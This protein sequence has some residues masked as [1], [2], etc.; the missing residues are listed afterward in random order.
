MGTKRL[1]VGKKQEEEK[2]VQSPCL[3]W[4]TRGKST[5]GKK[6]RR[7][8]GKEMRGE[9]QST[10][11]GGYA[12]RRDGAPAAAAG[13]A[14]QRQPPRTRHGPTLTTTE[15]HLRRR[16]QRVV[17]PGR[18][19]RRGPARRAARPSASAAGTLAVG[20][21]CRPARGGSRQ[22]RPRPRRR[23]RARGRRRR[24]PAAPRLPSSRAA[25][26]RAPGGAAPSCAG[27]GARGGRV[28][29]EAG[30]ASPCGRGERRVR[31]RRSYSNGKTGISGISLTLQQQ[32]V[33]WTA[34]GV[35]TNRL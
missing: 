31:G 28:S 11:L 30:A 6:G 32:W 15:S 5:R 19:S 18:Q 1:C 9:G 7:A 35:Q 10:H 13:G 12:A 14:P 27:E 22:R 3:A 16:R 4:C 20:A 2:H 17:T 24:W 21:L 8:G 23:R 34:H 26:T 25:P 29:G 33:Q